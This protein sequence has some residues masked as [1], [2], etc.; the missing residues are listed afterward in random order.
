M[1]PLYSR[2]SR[3]SLLHGEI[4]GVCHFLPLNHKLY[5]MLPKACR[6]WYDWP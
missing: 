4:D 3:W 5:P 2:G 1:L 6:R